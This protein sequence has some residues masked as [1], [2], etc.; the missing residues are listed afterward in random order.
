MK[1]FILFVLL[2]IV[3]TMFLLINETKKMT[4]QWILTGL[5]F[6]MGIILLFLISTNIIRF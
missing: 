5:Y 3:L 6:T 1:L 4:A 2:G